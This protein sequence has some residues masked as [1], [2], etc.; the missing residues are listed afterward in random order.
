VNHIVIIDADLRAVPNK[1]EDL[2][3]VDPSKKVA[4]QQFQRPLIFIGKGHRR[5]LQSIGVV[6]FKNSVSDAHRSPPIELLQH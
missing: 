3:I 1:L 4:H 2:W 6:Q 5:E